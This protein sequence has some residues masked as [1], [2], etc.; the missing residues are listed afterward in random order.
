MSFLSR[1]VTRTMM[2]RMMARGMYTPYSRPAGVVHRLLHSGGENYIVHDGQR[3]VHAVQQASRG[4]TPSPS[5][6]N[7]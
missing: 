5:L 2:T 3:Y 7:A 4:R 6:N 1:T